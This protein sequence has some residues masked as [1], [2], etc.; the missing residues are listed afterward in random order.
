MIPSAAPSTSNYVWD[1]FPPNRYR[2]PISLSP[3]SQGHKRTSKLPQIQQLD[4]VTVQSDTGPNL[5]VTPPS[6]TPRSDSDNCNMTVTVPVTTV[7]N[8]PL[9]CKLLHKSDGGDGETAQPSQRFRRMSGMQVIH[10]AIDE[11]A[12]F[13]KNV[14]QLILF[15]F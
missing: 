1:T 12:N 6:P 11:G 13:A 15:D 5:T 9:S 3:L 10:Q 14:N 8:K 7:S 4:L 2:V